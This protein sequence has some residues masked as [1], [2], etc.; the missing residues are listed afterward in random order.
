MQK[1]AIFLLVVGWMVSSAKCVAQQQGDSPQCS[2]VYQNRNQIDYGPLKLR[3][4]E[5]RTVIQVGKEERGRLPELVS[6]CSARRIINS[7]RVSKPMLGDD[8]N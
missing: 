1:L 3:V 5:G 7:W 8:S 4:V 2:T 6:S